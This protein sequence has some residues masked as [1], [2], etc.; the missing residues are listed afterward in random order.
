MSGLRRISIVMLCIF[1]TGCSGSTSA[2]PPAAAD[3]RRGPAPQAMSSRP[4]PPSI[5][6]INYV[7]AADG[8]HVIEF[9]GSG[10]ENGDIA[11]IRSANGGLLGSVDLEGDSVRR[12]GVVQ[13]PIADVGSHQVRIKNSHGQYSNSANLSIR[14]SEPAQPAAPTKHCSADLAGSPTTLYLGGGDAEKLFEQ[15]VTQDADIVGKLPYR[16]KIKFYEQEGPELA[17]RVVSLGEFEDL[18]VESR[19]DF[20]ERMKKQLRGRNAVSTP[21]LQEDAAREKAQFFRCDAN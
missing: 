10:F 2:K 18:F 8:R 17:L 9:T 7:T 11:E 19:S 21:A 16:M 4:P 3:S 20:L 14:D 13:F 5:H 15:Y 6:S 1:V 12:A